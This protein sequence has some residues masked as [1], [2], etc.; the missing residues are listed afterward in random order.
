[1]VQPLG[2]SF[3]G[4]ASQ[5]IDATD[6]CDSIDEDVSD[7]F[8]GTWRSA[9]TAIAT[10]DYS[11]NHS[12]VSVGSTNSNGSAYMQM[13]SIKPTCPNNLQSPG[14][15]DN[16]VHVSQSPS[17]L[18]M[19]SGDT[20]VGVTGSVSPSSLASSVVVAQGSIS[21]PNSSSQAAF[22]YN[23]PTSFTGNDL[24]KI[25]ISGTNSPS[26][27]QNSQACVSGVCASQLTNATIPP[28]VLI[29]MIQ[30]EA[31][32]TNVTTMAGVA[33]IARNRFGSAIFG[34]QYTT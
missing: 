29:Q 30:A 4:S 15:N 9:N 13:M 31:G 32:G 33:D 27:M 16:V 28:Q 23:K 26:G 25:S 18:N 17:I 12:G 24:W 3:Q 5:G 22:T 14:G 8:Y 11:G 20:G 1:L 19:S 7:T 6:T 34:G 10:V 2:I 21:N